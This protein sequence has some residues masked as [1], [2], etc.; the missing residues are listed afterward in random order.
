MKP[1]LQTSF[2]CLPEGPL[3]LTQASRGVWSQADAQGAAPKQ[4]LSPAKEW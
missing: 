4:T 1:L 2:L 3:A